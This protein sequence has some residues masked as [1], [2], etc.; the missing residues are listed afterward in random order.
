MDDT[1]GQPSIWSLQSTIAHL[2]YGALAAHVDVARP[3]VGLQ[4]ITLDQAIIDG[5]LLCATRSTSGPQKNVW[6]LPLIETYLRGRDLIASYGP[7]DDW[8]YT[9]NIYWRADSLAAI[10]DVRASLL[11]LIS[12]QTQLLD[13]NPQICV[14]SEL[15]SCE[16]LYFC[17]SAGE[18]SEVLPRD[19]GDVIDPQGTLCCVLRRL[20]NG[21]TYVEIVPTT[22]F[23]WARWSSDSPRRSQFSWQLFSEFLEK[24]VIRRARIHAVI[25]PQ[26]RD[27]ELAAECCAW[28]EKVPLP[29]T[30]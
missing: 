10:D 7:V 24:G 1:H 28:L 12:V 9:P 4:G 3:N 26:E 23:R 27:L 13:T 21:L 22:D 15:E 19:R 18:A 20:D 30:A 2:Q 16:D 6:P 17:W 25:M 11:L 29:L 14:T 8:P 5:Q